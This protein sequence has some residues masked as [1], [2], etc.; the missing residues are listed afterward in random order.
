MIITKIY[1]QDDGRMFVVVLNDDVC[2]NY[3]LDPEIY[4]PGGDTFL[5]EA[6]L[7]F[8]EA[9]LYDGSDPQVP[10][11]TQ[12]EPYAQKNLTLIVQVE[13]EARLYP[14]RMCPQ[15]QDFFLSELGEEVW[16]IVLDRDPHGQGVILDF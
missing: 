5:D 13:E 2:I 11:L 7:G 3:I 10:D 4:V 16:E 15:I 8:P 9:P 6:Q 12:A 14:H 1:Q